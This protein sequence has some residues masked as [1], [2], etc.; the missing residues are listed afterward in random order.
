[1]FHHIPSWH[2]QYRQPLEK[3]SRINLT[4]RRRFSNFSFFDFSAEVFAG[5]ETEESG[6][7]RPQ[8]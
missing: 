1:M 7:C 6:I 5:A 3:S 4:K 8:S 2:K